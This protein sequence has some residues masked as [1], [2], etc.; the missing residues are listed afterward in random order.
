MTSDGPISIPAGGI[1]VPPSAPPV[2]ETRAADHPQFS[3]V[4]RPAA[5]RSVQPAVD[6]GLG[7]VPEAMYAVRMLGWRSKLRRARSLRM[8]VRRSA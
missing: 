2:P 1:E 3:E 4:V 8:V 5:G 7:Q 6:R